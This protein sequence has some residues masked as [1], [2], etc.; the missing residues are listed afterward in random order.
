MFKVSEYVIFE[1]KVNALSAIF[2]SKFHP[3]IGKKK[4]F[5]LFF[6]SLR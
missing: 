2:V 4:L 5:T 1:P 3:N 6:N